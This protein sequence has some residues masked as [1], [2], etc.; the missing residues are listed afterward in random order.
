MVRMKM[1]VKMRKRV[2]EESKDSG[3]GELRGVLMME[4]MAK[5]ASPA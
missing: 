2:E 5:S 3:G 4:I 1:N